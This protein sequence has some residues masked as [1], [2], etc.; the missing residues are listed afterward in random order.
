MDNTLQPNL[1]IGE[2]VS[3]V[4]QT[5]DDVILDDDDDGSSIV[6]LARNVIGS[7]GDLTSFDE[8]VQQCDSDDQP[9]ILSDLSNLI[10]V[11]Q[12]LHQVLEE[13][14]KLKKILDKSEIV[15]Q[16]NFDRMQKVLQEDFMTLCQDHN[17]KY[18]QSKQ[19][20]DQMKAENAL[21]R[22]SII[23]RDVFQI[24][25]L[26]CN[27]PKS[28]SVPEVVAKSSSLN[29]SSYLSA[30]IENEP[31][32]AQNN[33]LTETIEIFP[34]RMRNSSLDND[35]MVVPLKTDETTHLP[36]VE[37]QSS[38]MKSGLVNVLVDTQ[39]PTTETQC[40]TTA[41][42]TPSMVIHSNLT[43]NKILSLADINIE[44]QK[45]LEQ[46]KVLTEQ[47]EK[48]MV[49]QKDVISPSNDQSKKVTQE[50][51]RM[52]QLIANN[53]SNDIA[54]ENNAS[55]TEKRN[56]TQERES[57][58]KLKIPSANHVSLQGMERE[59]RKTSDTVVSEKKRK[60]LFEAEIKKPMK[61]TTAEQKI[62]IIH[63][64]ETAVQNQLQII[65][66]NQ[67]KRLQNISESITPVELSKLVDE[68]LVLQGQSTKLTKNLDESNTFYTSKEGSSRKRKSIEESRKLL[69]DEIKSHEEEREALTK[70]NALLK[71]KCDALE[72]DV[73]KFNTELTKSHKMITSLRKEITELQKTADAVD[74]YKFKNNSQVNVILR[75]LEAE[76]KKEIERLSNEIEKIEK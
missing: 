13:N 63:E 25:D 62:G 50:E 66:I 35:M 61:S 38:S 21:L 5:Q 46:N 16:Q 12:K 75:K 20:I 48:L 64:K 11:E 70:E 56:L 54:S 6:V 36:D 47:C 33:S 71:S 8:E 59:K 51:K 32:L 26:I 27:Q 14:K 60:K 28:V 2:P 49:C 10:G 9:S 72:V 15:M 67:D 7:I 69:D 45:L 31:S 30:S 34:S 52:D 39:I 41:T 43:Q 23:K 68:V 73:K 74:A 4:S 57:S 76:Q 55:H 53:F 22:V 3:N 24:W 44:L 65:K 40:V 37:M 1:E 17:R 58:P 29:T 18:I 42:E 19:F